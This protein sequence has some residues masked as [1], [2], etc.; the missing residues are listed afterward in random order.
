MR[1]IGNLGGKGTGAAAK[2]A[3]ATP[4]IAALKNESP[5]KHIHTKVSESGGKPSAP[6]KK[7]PKEQSKDAPRPLSGAVTLLSRAKTNRIAMFI[8]L[9]NTRISKNNLEELFYNITAKHEVVLAKVYGYDE[10][11]EEFKEV[12]E[13]YNM[14][15]A[16][17]MRYKPVGIDVTDI[18]VPLDAYEC[19][20]KNSRSVDMI[21]VWCHPCDLSVLFEK[22]IDCGVSTATI[23]HP[24]MDCNNK[25]VSD[26]IRLF[27]PYDID[28]GVYA[29]GNTNQGETETKT[30]SESGAEPAKESAPEFTAEPAESQEDGGEPQDTGGPQFISP[31]QS[32]PAKFVPEGE[33]DTGVTET[34]G[35]GSEAEQPEMVDATEDDTRLMVQEMLA[36]MGFD[37]GKDGGGAEEAANKQ[38]DT[39]G[40]DDIPPA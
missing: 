23:D 3:V 34:Y 20:Q 7:P 9:D 38:G 11:K 12:I 31:E 10:N 29:Y 40:L 5:I 26:K 21:F 37:F 14:Q 27:S 22:I 13:K 1:S 28:R 24:A 36:D 25:F 16:G 19:A 15:T 30:E 32:Q 18:R 35:F 6:A 4:V 8:D 33:E 39:G 17:R 2:S